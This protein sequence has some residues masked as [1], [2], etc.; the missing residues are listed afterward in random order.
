MK[1]AVQDSSGRRSKLL[2]RS[3]H[4]RTLMWGNVL[5]PRTAAFELLKSTGSNNTVRFWQ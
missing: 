1:L 2:R 3:V 4:P 5:P